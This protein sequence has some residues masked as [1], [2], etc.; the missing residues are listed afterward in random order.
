[1]AEQIVGAAMFR[2]TC[3]CGSQLLA[4]GQFTADHCAEYRQFIAANGPPSGMRKAM[5][6]GVRSMYL[7]LLQQVAADTE[8]TGETLF[9]NGHGDATEQI[10]GPA[11]RAWKDVIDGEKAADVGM[12]CLTN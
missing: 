7:D 10:L 11:T 5:D 4:S 3:Q 9:G 8:A 6:I 1:L 2:M 12:Q